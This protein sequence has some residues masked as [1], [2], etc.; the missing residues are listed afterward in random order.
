M[1]TGLLGPRA[2][3]IVSDYHDDAQSSNQIVQNRLHA[4]NMARP[5]SGN[6]SQSAAPISAR[7]ALRRLASLGFG[8]KDNFASRSSFRPQTIQVVLPTR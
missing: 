4:A 1:I 5:A 3:T 7:P 6:N 8:A 2:M